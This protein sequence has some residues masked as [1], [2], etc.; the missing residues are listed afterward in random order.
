MAFTSEEVASAAGLAQAAFYLLAAGYFNFSRPANLAKRALAVYLT[1]EGA[2]EIWNAASMSGL[3]DDPARTNIFGDLLAAGLLSFAGFFYAFPR[4]PRVGEPAFWWWGFGAAYVLV[5][6]FVIIV[7]QRA[8]PPGQALVPFD[9]PL[10]QAMMTWGLAV[11]MWC[12]VVSAWLRAQEQSD[13]ARH[14]NRVIA[15]GMAAI[16]FGRTGAYFAYWSGMALGLDPPFRPLSADHPWDPYNTTNL[17][18]ALIRLA[19]PAAAIWWLRRRGFRGPLELALIAFGFVATIPELFSP[20]TF[21]EQQGV[22]QVIIPLYVVAR[23]GGFDTP[24]PERV[25][26]TLVAVAAGTFTFVVIELAFVASTQGSTLAGVLTLPVAL[27]IGIGVVLALLP[28]GGTISAAYSWATGNEA[29]RNRILYETALRRELAVAPHPEDAFERLRPLRA[30]LG[31]S[32][33][34]HEKISLLLQKGPGAGRL[35]FGRYRLVREL[36]S[37]GAGTA[38]LYHDTQT[39]RQVVIKRLHLRGDD[40]D[41]AVAEARVLASV[42][43]P[44]VVILHDVERV[45]DEAFLIMEH[46][47]GGSL[48]DRLSQGPLAQRDFHALATQLLAALQAVHDRGLVHRDVKPSNVLFD[49]AGTA[50]LAD[51][52]AARSAGADTTIATGSPPGGVGTIHYMSPEAARGRG[53]TARSDLYSAAA[54]LYEARTGQPLLAPRD[55]ESAVELLIRAASVRRFAR[56]VPGGPALQ[57]WFTKALAPSPSDRFA[58]AKEMADALAKTDPARKDLA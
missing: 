14:A 13:P 56:A 12:L 25:P 48:K 57:E 35:L 10:G 53:V 44:N 58:S 38:R 54:T 32:D 50:K 22:L 20:F 19:A 51:F 52:G 55:G 28:R 1:I 29:A 34:E 27:A 21:V 47:E 9:S 46:L 49:G 36:G 2:T 6:V 11:P 3:L 42:R 15:S 31:L 18:F 16:L 39:E 30:S 23:Y 40:L 33:R 37:G 8:F 41:R 45:G 7:G 26:G 4:R 43:H 17:G 5:Q 24:V